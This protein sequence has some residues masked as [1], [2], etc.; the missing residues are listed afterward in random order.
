MAPSVAAAADAGSSG[1]SHR[2][3]AC[4]RCVAHRQLH[5]RRLRQRGSR[6]RRRQMTPPPKLSPAR[7]P[8]S[9]AVSRRSR[10]AEA[11]GRRWVPARVT[12]GAPQTKPPSGAATSAA[13]SSSSEGGHDSRSSSG[14][15]TIDAISISS[16]ASVSSGMS[17]SATAAEGGSGAITGIEIAS[18]SSGISVSIWPARLRRISTSACSR[19][20]RA[21]GIATS[22]PERSCARTS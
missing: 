11:R 10:R 3:A 4:R 9:R 21:V 1:G 18:V 22:L 17:S 19:S 5:D 14:I 8:R 13:S 7:W 20:S 12:Q 15:S 2:V 16:T 6:R